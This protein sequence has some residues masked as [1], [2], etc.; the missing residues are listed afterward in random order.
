MCSNL[1]HFVASGTPCSN[2][3]SGRTPPI[4]SL[5]WRFEG[6]N[7]DLSLQSGERIWSEAFKAPNK[8]PNQRYPFLTVPNG[9]PVRRYVNKIDLSPPS[10]PVSVINRKKHLHHTHI[11]LICAFRFSGSPRP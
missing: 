4:A 5:V 8:A 10:N 11:P 9:Q 6:L 3:D 2:L 7:T 1:N